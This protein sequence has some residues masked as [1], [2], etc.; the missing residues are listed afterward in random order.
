MRSREFHAGCQNLKKRK[1][2]VNWVGNA[3]EKPT[4]NVFPHERRTIK[5][6]Y[7]FNVRRVRPRG[8][9][10]LLGSSHLIEI[11]P[12]LDEFE[13][14]RKGKGSRDRLCA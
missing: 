10:Q 8:P 14:G 2:V 11:S 7:I 6:V 12:L 3:Q 1:I 9:S 13:D 5:R 4:F